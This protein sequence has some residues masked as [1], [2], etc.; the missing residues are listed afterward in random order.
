MKSGSLYHG[1]LELER[2]RGFKF[3]RAAEHMPEASASS[4]IK[5]STARACRVLA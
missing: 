4:S 5:S 3:R 2:M 1:S